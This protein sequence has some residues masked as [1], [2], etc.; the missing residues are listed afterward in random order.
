[1]HTL[2]IQRI[3]FLFL[4]IAFI[5]TG[6]YI[7]LAYLMVYYLSFEYLNSNKKYKEISAHK[8]YNWLFVIYPA[9]ILLVR[10]R[11]FNFTETVVYHL[12]T[13]EHL[14]FAFL[15]C[16]T[17]SIYLQLFNFLSNNDLLKLFTVFGLLNF[18]G[19]LNEYFQNFYHQLPLFHLE[20]D[21]L[22]DMTVNLLGSTLFVIVSLFSKVKSK[23]NKTQKSL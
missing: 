6:V 23:Q 11:L 17:L 21:D 15:I 4:T 14:F 10:G 16:L 8:I 1:M 20:Q 13:A 2:R 12:N 5:S 22:K 9:F 3:L 19:I 18:I 7:L